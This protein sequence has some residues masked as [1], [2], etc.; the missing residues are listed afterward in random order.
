MRFQISNDKSASIRE[1]S[2]K[3]FQGALIAECSCSVEIFAEKFTI[4]RMSM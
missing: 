2:E 3:R 4:P 1:Q